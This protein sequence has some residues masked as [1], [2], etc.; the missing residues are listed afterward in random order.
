ML[1][2]RTDSLLQDF[3]RPLRAYLE[4]TLHLNLSLDKWDGTK[5]LPHFLVHRYRFCEATIAGQPCLFAIDQ[6]TDDDTP[7]QI[8]KQV[9][10]IQREFPGIVVYAT[11]SLSSTRR[12]RLIAAGI[13]F[14]VPNNQL[15]IPQLALDLREVFRSQKKRGSDQL[16]PAAQA[17]FF[18]SILH[19]TQS[20]QHSTERTPSHLARALGYSAMSVGRGFDELSDFGLAEIQARGRQKFLVLGADSRQLIAKSRELLRSPVRSTQ[21]ADCQPLI[22]PMKIAGESALAHLTG[23]SSPDLPVY[24]IHGDDWHLIQKQGAKQVKEREEATA[25]IEVWHYHPERLSGDATVDALSLYAQFWNDPNER[26]AKA[27]QE[28][29]ED[30]AW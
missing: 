13:A 26:I 29:L 2:R 11:D 16:S 12:S 18:F 28:A 15:Y 30:V 9:S 10:A 27:A 17:I 6:K 22:P 21:L 3:T 8:S 1:D 23:L 19:P 5:R 24:A 20:G 25:R 4:K 14:V 7:G